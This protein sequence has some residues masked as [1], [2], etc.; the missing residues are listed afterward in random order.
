M[1]F[2]SRLGKQFNFHKRKRP[3]LS[4]ERKTAGFTLTELLVVVAIA[5]VIVSAL[6][7]LVVELVGTEQRESTRTETQ[8]SM[9]RALNY[10]AADLRQAVYIYGDEANPQDAASSPSYINYLPDEFVDDDF[11]P[12]LAFW[13]PRSIDLEKR[14]ASGSGLPDFDDCLTTFPDNNDDQDVRLR[15]ECQ[16]IW[17]QRRAYSLVVYFQVPNDE[18][19]PDGKWKGQSRIARYELFKYDNLNSNN[20]T[21]VFD[22]TP[23]FVDPAELGSDAFQSW[24]YSGTVDCQDTACVDDL[25]APGDPSFADNPP[26]VLVDFVDAPDEVRNGEPT[27]CENLGGSAGQYKRVP[28]ADAGN[29]K[30]SNSF[31]ICLRDTNGVLGE[32]QDVIVYLRGNANGRAGSTTDSFLPT[33]QT[34]ITMRGIID[35][36]VGGAA[37]AP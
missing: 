32:S 10:I 4:P 3:M 15:R 17:K 36:N 30:A 12:V 9:Q 35:K 8:R 16:S 22:R 6:M 33:L 34:R 29:P 19:N 26:D 14:I 21:A 23:G 31:F 37:T 25:G 20:A 7:A 5:G 1:S 11:R 27:T 18:G 24:P 2:R 28:S 13:K